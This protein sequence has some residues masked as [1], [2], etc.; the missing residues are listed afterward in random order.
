[1][2]EPE[3]MPDSPEM[4]EGQFDFDPAGPQAVYDMLRAHSPVL[5]TDQGGTI[6]ARHEDVEFA[7]RNADIFSSDMEAVSIGNVRPLI[8][9]QINP[10]EHVKYRRLLDPLFAPKQVALLEN[11]VRK[12]S[13]QLIDD[14]IGSGECEFNSAFAIPLPCTVFLRLLG[15]P[16]E[17]L[18]LFLE[19][20]DNI[21]RPNGEAAQMP[22]EEF[23]RIQAETGQRI[24][25]YFD[26]VLDERERQPRD[27]MLTGFLEAD[28]DG[29]RL[30]REDILDICYLFLLA[31]LDTVTASV[32]CMVSYLAQ[33]PEQR[34]R[35]VEDPSQIPGAVEELLRWET[36][37]PG[38]PRVVAED[39]ELSG[40]RLEAGE[41][42]TVL[43]GSANIDERGFPQPS[44]V[45]FERPANRHLA[46][47]GGVHRCLGSHLAR[48]EL[49]VALEQLHERI[50]DYSIKPGETPQYTM[51]IR[52]VEHLPLV[53]TPPS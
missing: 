26:K 10:P 22:E 20:K 36:P 48:L 5:R 19:L 3:A 25:A 33:H 41:R 17:D 45:D 52:A 2:S 1:M 44:D 30:T 16:L 51:G 34:Q 11:D 24:Y 29:N 47:G 31:G 8:P 40:E 53:F 38:V 14:F 49:R 43:L 12:L 32:G 21:I 23:T 28:V 6:I 27:D 15:L 18:D 50:P 42:V 7:L 46:F 35:L 9:L 39:V 4:P 13:N 37:V